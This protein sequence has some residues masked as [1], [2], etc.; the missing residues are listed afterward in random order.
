MRATN[1][2]RALEA[3]PASIGDMRIPGVTRGEGA[4]IVDP[5]V[6]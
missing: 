4:M 5:R 6:A 1:S 2:D 3:S